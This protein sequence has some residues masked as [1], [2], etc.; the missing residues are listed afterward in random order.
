MQRR[1]GLTTE[2]HFVKPPFLFKSGSNFRVDI[3]CG[4]SQREL[5]GRCVLNIK[6]DK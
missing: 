3:V 2:Q 6:Y 4:D 5:W 1:S